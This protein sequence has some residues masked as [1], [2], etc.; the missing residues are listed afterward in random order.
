MN[1]LDNDF[2]INYMFTSKLSKDERF[3]ISFLNSSK[4][5]SSG[6]SKAMIMKTQFIDPLLKARKKCDELQSSLSQLQSELDKFKEDQ[7]NVD[8]VRGIL[9]E[10][11]VATALTK[12][13]STAV[14]KDKGEK[15]ILDTFTKHEQILYEVTQ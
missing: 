4:M 15:Q 12:G 14:I 9:T 8:A 13:D 3:R 1:G 5:A 11:R 10:L 6:T 7:T 2:L